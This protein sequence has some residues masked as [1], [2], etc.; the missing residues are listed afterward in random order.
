MKK[1][2]ML[3]SL[4]LILIS[5]AAGKQN[6]ARLQALD[7][8]HFKKTMTIKDDELEINVEFNTQKGFHVELGAGVQFLAGMAAGLA[9]ESGRGATMGTDYFLRAYLNKQTGQKIYQVCSSIKYSDN[10]WRFY[11]TANFGKPLRS[12]KTDNVGSDVKCSGKGRS[13]TYTE[14]II[15][16]VPEDELLRAIS[17]Y[18]PNSPEIQLWSFKLKAQSG[19]DQKSNIALQE[20]VALLEIVKNYQPVNTQ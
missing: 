9:S 15:F 13:C 17:K 18:D 7:V 3:L 4:G 5:C 10:N 8:E 1:L 12:V 2:V 11:D 20:I 16:Q 6:K 14:D 19:N